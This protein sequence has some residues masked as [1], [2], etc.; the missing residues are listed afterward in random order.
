MPPVLA[1]LSMQ[2]VTARNRKWH[3]V[4]AAG[5][6]ETCLRAG[7][8]HVDR[9]LEGACRG[10]HRALALALIANGATDVDRG[11]RGACRSG[12]VALVLTIVANGATCWEFGFR[13]AARGGHVAIARLLLAK[14]QKCN[15]NRA[16][17][18]ACRGGHAAFVQFLNELRI[19]SWSAGLGGACRGGH[20]ALALATLQK[21]AMIGEAMHW[22]CRG[23]HREVAHT[24]IAKSRRSLE[25]GTFS[26]VLRRRH[27][28][29]AA[30]DRKR[31]N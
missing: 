3:K 4:A 14:Y 10:G 23:G 11:L 29:C 16:M 24:L 5:E 18:E 22:A 7:A 27:A 6:F 28:A 13:G 20:D 31:C 17:F 12:E 19:T 2:F 8:D 26:R 25:A 30:Y 21:G 1:A 9:C 15:L